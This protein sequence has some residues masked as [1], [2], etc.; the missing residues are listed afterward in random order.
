[1]L[2]VERESPQHYTK[3][4]LTMPALTRTL[5]SHR[6]LL[7]QVRPPMQW[8]EFDLKDPALLQLVENGANPP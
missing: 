5:E 6:T 1:M 8:P 4:P 2:G 7:L 3:S